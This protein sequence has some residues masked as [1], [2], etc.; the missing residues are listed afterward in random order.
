MKPLSRLAIPVLLGALIPGLSLADPSV[1]LSKHDQ[2]LYERAFA[3][4]D[5]GRWTAAHNAA[6]QA[7]ER[8]PAKV[9]RW[10]HMT[11]ARPGA[12]LR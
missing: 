10:M 12:S 4:A 9:L 7:R 6:A 2:R 3:A 11:R 1:R 8:L 5:R